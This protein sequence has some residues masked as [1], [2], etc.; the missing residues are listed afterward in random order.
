MANV[1]S[2]SENLF[3]Y[4]CDFFVI[5]C[6]AQNQLILRNEK[7]AFVKGFCWANTKLTQKTGFQ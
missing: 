3:F 7:L 1:I 4:F 6:L 2:V 5:L